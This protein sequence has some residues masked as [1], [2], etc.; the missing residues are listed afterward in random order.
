MKRIN[1]LFSGFFLLFLV[2]SSIQPLYSSSVW[3]KTYWIQ[4]YDKTMKK[5]YTRVYA[6]I[7]HLGSPYRN[8]RGG[9]MVKLPKG[10]RKTKHLRPF[11]DFLKNFFPEQKEYEK[12]IIAAFPL[13]DHF[14]EF[15]M[16][17]KWMTGMKQ[18]IEY[19]STTLLPN[20]YLAMLRNKKSTRTLNH[21]IQERTAS[22]KAKAKFFYLV[23]PISISQENGVAEIYPGLFD[24]INRE[25]S[26]N[27]QLLEKMKIPY[28]DLRQGM[29]QFSWNKN[30]RKFFFKGDHHWKVDGA[31]LAAKLTAAYM[32]QHC[33]T[34]YDL[35]FFDPD[36]FYR[37]RYKDI[38]IGSLA[39][40][41]SLAYLSQKEDFDILYPDYKT[42][43]TLENPSKSFKTR[44]NFSILL[45][46]NHNHYNSYH[47]NNYDV[48]LDQ[49]Q[50]ILRITNHLINRKSGKKILI[51]K[52]SYAN[53]MVPYLALQTR[54]IV[55]V[56]P[57]LFKVTQI[58]KF[59]RQEKPDIVI[60]IFMLHFAPPS[61]KNR[62][63]KAVKS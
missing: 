45:F 46:H 24:R 42:D 61:G 7:R 56:D 15:N 5:Y 2:L 59:I 4:Q 3:L 43:F 35:R 23:R 50:P 38:F 9:S 10:N 32:N 34:K 1:Q 11:F 21:V 22:Q 28:L 60:N 27:I 14:S 52:D 31:L 62:N 13:R 18:P 37:V 57:R 12:K 51:I 30:F 8:T 44:G 6:P 58:P 19:E 48:F 20:H 26:D 54:E 47:A 29:G 16:A 49:D 40:K 36:V 39:K 63:K 53:A 25:I 33:G 55:M 17:V 41:L